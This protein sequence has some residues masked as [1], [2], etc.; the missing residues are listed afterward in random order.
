MVKPIVQLKNVSFT[1]PGA[2]NTVL[3][4]A[5]LTINEGEFL[6][7]IGGNGSGKSTLCKTFNGLI[8]KFYVGDFEG[9]VLV[10][11]MLTADYTVAQLSKDI[12]YVYQDFEN[13][14]MRPT[15]IEDASFVPLNY[16]LAD[17]KERGEWALKV[18]G[19]TP[20]RNEFIW[21]LSG[22]QK[23][24]LALAGVL[25]MKPKILIVDEPVA[26]LDPQH[27]EEVYDILKK[28][29]KDHGITII[30]I[31]HHTE[32]IAKYC[33]QVVLMERGKVLWKK[34]VKDALS[35]VSEL[36]GHSIYPPQVTQAAYLL[37]DFL[38][39]DSY[40]PITVDDAVKHFHKGK[41]ENNDIDESAEISQRLLKKEKKI[42]Q[43][44]NVSLQYRTFK[45]QKKQVLSNINLNLHEGDMVALVGNNG[46]GK[47]SLMKLIT[48]INKPTE[49][50][51]FI[52]ELKTANT[53]AERLGDI[54]SFVYQ[55]PEEMFID[56]SVRKD[57]E[58]YL[59]VRKVPD[60]EKL[61]DQLLEDFSLTEIQHRDG[62][63][64]SGGQQRRV[65]LAIG[66]A[67]KPSIILLD[68]PTANLDIATKKQVVHMLE[69]LKKH[70]QT[71]VVA[72]HDMQLVSEWANRI[73]VMNK[74]TIICD[75]NRQEVFGDEDLMQK[76][77]L[78]SPQ[79]LQL[80]NALHMNP[81]CY[82]VA[83]FAS[84]WNVKKV[85]G[86]I[87]EYCEEFA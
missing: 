50:D 62:R 28:L 65:S 41:V 44:N 26:Q 36:I 6:A 48:G 37:D 33:E 66:A 80:S 64:L 56:D 60:Y 27:A 51:V 71:V 29:N 84:R 18:T 45:K 15:V 74:G 35:Q 14:L 16:G 68:E 19:L 83:D 70:V 79:I 31:E 55:N 61:V 34:C 63:L 17:Y 24:L 2:E 67:M 87:S 54:V 49:G 13:Q 59:K 5:S 43:F 46:A 47:S 75:G 11:E 57:I 10:Q 73:V 39:K 7:I 20:L 3:N 53:S 78:S 32:F 21:Q 1:Y 86:G 12:G 8:P 76:A 72:T 77:G 81:L 42:V 82:T 30:V 38:K 23:H 58:F 69:K 85:E 52:Q 4:N 25:A 9:E 40:Y 22:G